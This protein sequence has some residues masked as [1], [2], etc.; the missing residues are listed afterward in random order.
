LLGTSADK[1]TK[2]T[3]QWDLHPPEFYEQVYAGG[4]IP[5]RIVDIVP[6][7]CLRNWGDLVER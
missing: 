2:N 3:L 5:A 1:R 4:G 7:H 6:D